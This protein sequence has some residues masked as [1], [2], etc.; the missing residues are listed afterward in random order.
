VFNWNGWQWL[1]FGGCVFLACI[2]IAIVLLAWKQ[3]T[4]PNDR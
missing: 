2:G 3:V 1:G 4:K